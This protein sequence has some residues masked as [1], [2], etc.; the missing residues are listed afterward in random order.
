[1]VE[2]KP[3]KARLQSSERDKHVIY[4][5]KADPGSSRYIWAPPGTSSDGVSAPLGSFTVPACTFVEV[6]GAGPDHHRA[7]T[8]YSRAVAPWSMVG[9][10]V[11]RCTA[12]ESVPVSGGGRVRARGT[13]W[14]YAPGVRC[15]FRR[16]N[17]RVTSCMRPGGRTSPG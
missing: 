16:R 2:S 8:V 14:T 13:H 7:F 17:D 15:G 4:Y 1:M 9:A 11:G 12:C 6:R 3:S 5:Y 10:V